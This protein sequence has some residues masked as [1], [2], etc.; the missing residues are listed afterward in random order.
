MGNL[1]VDISGFNAL[2]VPCN[3]SRGTELTVKAVIDGVEH[4]GT[5]TM[6][7]APE[8]QDLLLP[9]AGKKLNSI[10]LNLAMGDL[11]RCPTFCKALLRPVRLERGQAELD[12]LTVCDEP[13]G[14]AGSSGFLLAKNKLALADDRFVLSR[15]PF[16]VEV[17]VC[18][19]KPTGCKLAGTRQTFAGYPGN[20]GWAL[21]MGSG[22]FT[23]TVEDQDK[24]VSSANGGGWLGRYTPYHVVAVRD[25]PNHKLRLY[26]NGAKVAETD[27]KGS[28]VFG[29]ER[30][31]LGLSFDPWLGSGMAGLLQYVKVHD[32]ALTENEAKACSAK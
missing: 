1:N 29:D 24:M 25:F 7:H 27:E 19:I 28:G 13:V 12:T 30:R 16:S 22:G 17:K 31:T 15:R 6:G 26:V 4:V 23:F 14:L 5:P 18:I 3:L 10:S 21:G 9:L 2:A 8:W 11:D 20:P 32:R